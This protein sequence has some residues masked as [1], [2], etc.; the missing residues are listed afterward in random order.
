MKKRIELLPYQ[1]SVADLIPDSL[2][3]EA[4]KD[5]CTTAEDREKI[6][7]RLRGENGRQKTS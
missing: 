3:A 2:L 7:A 1:D 4:L 6:K 5:P